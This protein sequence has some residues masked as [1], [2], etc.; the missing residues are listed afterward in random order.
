MANR[1]DSST[2]SCALVRGR[3]RRAAG[4]KRLRGTGR[5]GVWQNGAASST[6]SCAPHVRAALF[7][8]CVAS[9]LLLLLLLH[10]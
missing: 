3:R 9:A 5:P 1:T 8:H 10:T 7:E 4:S 6:R 2:R